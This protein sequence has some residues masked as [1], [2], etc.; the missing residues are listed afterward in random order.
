LTLEINV[1]AFRIDVLSDTLALRSFP[2]AVGM[3]RYP[4]PVGD[5]TIAEVQWNPWWRPPD[6]PWAA[7]DTVTPPGP[8]NPMGKV[9]LPLSPL[10]YMHGTPVPSSI[11]KAASHAC[12]RMHNADAI[13]LARL[14]QSAAGADITESGVDSLLRRW[15]PTRRVVLA[16]PVPV[17]IVYRLVERRSDVLAFHPDVYRRGGANPAS[18]ALALLAAAGYD[19]TLVDRSRLERAARDGSRSATTVKIQDL[20][21]P[22]ADGDV[23]PV[24]RVQPPVVTSRVSHD[25]SQERP[26][27]AQFAGACPAE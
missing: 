21:L 14:L 17:R 25:H 16:I 19:T 22:S 27:D 8:G 24:A 11:G 10:L 26:Y 15:R 18:D 5:F 1:P 6:S 3:R 4:T 2:V 7:E 9:K 23:P 13:E 12:I 20:F